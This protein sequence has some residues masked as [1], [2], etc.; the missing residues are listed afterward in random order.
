[1]QI[2]NEYFNDLIFTYAETKQLYAVYVVAIHSMIG[3]DKCQYILAFVPD[4]LGIQKT[5]KLRDL[6]WKNLQTR[7]LPHDSYKVKRQAWKAPNQ[8]NNGTAGNIYNINLKVVSRDANYSTYKADKDTF[9]FEILMINTSSKKTI[10]QYPNSMNLHYAIDQFN[11]IFNYIGNEHPINLM[12]N[13]TSEN[14]TY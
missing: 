9:P 8:L 12:S 3:G 4:H 5:S 11:T 14:N 1:M 6:P 2:L 10:Y 7:T 13:T